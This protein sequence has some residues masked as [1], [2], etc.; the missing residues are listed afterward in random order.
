M[1]YVAINPSTGE[2]IR[3]YPTLTPAE[4]KSALQRAR[5]A[6]EA[7][8]DTSFVERSSVLR[9]V[10]RR[11]RA[12]APEH[13][14]LMA[15][16]MGKPVKAGQS[17]AEKCAWVCEYY[18]DNAER[19]L[20]D[21]EALTDARRSYVAYRPLG[22]VLAIM[23]WNFPYWQVMR[24]AAPSLMAGNTVLLK[25]APNVPGCAERLEGLFTSAG[26]PTGCF[27]EPLRDEPASGCR[28]PGFK[29]PWR[30]R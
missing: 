5:K 30:K 23:P 25:H 12:E 6:F 7:W 3:S 14:R 11:L 28:N 2:E 29:S 16:E 17:E 1:T 20:A 8:R 26:L 13:G 19:F 18:A 27:P 9:E 22:P 15:E 21:E 24:F 4:L 10:A